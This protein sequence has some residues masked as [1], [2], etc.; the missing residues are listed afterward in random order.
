MTL[1]TGTKVMIRNATL[2]GKEVIEGVA[3]IK[4][5]THRLD[6]YMVRFDEDGKY[7]TKAELYLRYV[8]PEH[9]IIQ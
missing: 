1:D 8:L 9:V 2:D 7:G 3:T 6:Y 4:K 5:V